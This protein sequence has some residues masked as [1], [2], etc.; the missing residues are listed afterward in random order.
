MVLPLD[1]SF[2]ARRRQLAAYRA[3]SSE[4]RLRLADQLSDDVRTLTRS[5]I[6]A[7]HSG[8]MSEDEVDAALARI[9]LGAMVAA[10]VMARNPGSRR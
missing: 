8:V 6:R 3:M 1:T 5:G 10:A 7:R 2:D 4:D 9:L